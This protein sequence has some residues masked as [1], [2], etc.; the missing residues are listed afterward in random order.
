MSRQT[1]NDSLQRL[2]LVED[3]SRR[4]HRLCSWSHSFQSFD[5][6]NGK[7]SRRQ[8]NSGQIVVEYVLL[9]VVAVTLAILIT[10]L[11]I[12]PKKDNPGFVINA[13]EAMIQQIG[14]EMPDDISR[15]KK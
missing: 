7:L 3:P 13:W 4:R 11:V 9:L 8:S 14:V 2:R 15:G 5:Y 1:K 6:R 10:K 12:S